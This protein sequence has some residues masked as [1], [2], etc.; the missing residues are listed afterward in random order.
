[1]SI[2]LRNNFLVL[3]GIV[4]GATGGWCYYHFVGCSSGTCLITSHPI[5]STMYGGFMGGLLFSTFKREKTINR[6]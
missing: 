1:M 2:F 3:S 6:K 4:L 5:N